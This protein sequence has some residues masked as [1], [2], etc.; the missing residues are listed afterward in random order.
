M[1]KWICCGLWDGDVSEAKDM[2]VRMGSVT[3]ES[4][5]LFYFIYFS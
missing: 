3:E 5:S 1:W 2:N 4:F